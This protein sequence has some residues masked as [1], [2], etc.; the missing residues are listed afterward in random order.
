[1]V[2]VFR[3][4]CTVRNDLGTVVVDTHRPAGA[5]LSEEWHGPDGSSQMT[6]ALRSPGHDR[7]QRRL[8]VV[9]AWGLWLLALTANLL[10]YVFFV[11]PDQTRSAAVETF[12]W[13]TG[14]L[15]FMMFLTVGTLIVARRPRK[16]IG[17]LC[18]AIGA[19]VSFSG[20]GSSDAAR[21][22][23]ADPDRIPGALVLHLLGQVLFLVPMLG[24]LP[25][26]VLLFPTGRPPSPRWRPV[27]WIVAVGLAL[28]V[29]SVMLK[30][31][32]AGDGLPANPLGLDGA[33]GLLAS[34]GAVSGLLFALFVV[35]VLASLVVRFRRARGDERQQLKWLVY[36]VV[37]FAL[38]IPTLGR[39]VEQVP[40]PFVGPVF[41]AVM[42][43]IIPVAIG[44]AV[45]KYR[46]YDIDRVISRTLVYALLT[47]LLAGVYAG[48]VL[49]L[50]QV[51]GGVGRDPPSWMVAGATLAVAALFQPARRRI[52]AVVDRR[53][54]RRNYD[55]AK[56]VEAFSARLRDEVDLD[57]LSA[58]LLAVVDETM[59]PTTAWLWLRQS[60]NP[61]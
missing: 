52:Q 15:P 53:F 46:L 13:A 54:N 25:V 7:E 17:W 10:T 24:L 58:G 32:P 29:T 22:I 28:Y 50:G 16:V 43:S 12:D 55:A 4:G 56:T 38:L 18:C 36:G 44:L 8:P 9:V 5:S 1:M 48:A 23:A 2:L 34:V 51:F 61:R 6:A 3:C 42:F 11:V 39:V 37:L 35:L 40:S 14:W 41:A 49:V 27:L 19:A 31:G 60:A 20:F 30:P 45:L 47:A 26:L 57:T 33:E 59:Q 21:S